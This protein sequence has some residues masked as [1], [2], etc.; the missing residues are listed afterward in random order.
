MY[1]P[2][3]P[4]SY[5]ESEQ[6]Y[7]KQDEIDKVTEWKRFNT[8]NKIDSLQKGL[9]P[10][11]LDIKW[12]WTDLYFENEEYRESRYVR[13]HC[14]HVT[15]LMNTIC[16]NERK[17]RFFSG[18]MMEL[19]KKN[20]IKPFLV[21]IDNKFIS[22]D[23]IKVVRSDTW[24][25]LIVNG[26]VKFIKPQKL[27]ILY[28]PCHIRYDDT[29]SGFEDGIDLLSFDNNGLFD[30]DNPTYIINTDEKDMAGFKYRDV[31]DDSFD[32]AIDPKR[33]ITP[34]NIVVFDSDTRELNN[35]CDI[36]TE[37]ENMIR[38][39]K[40]PY[41]AFIDNDIFHFTDYEAYVKDISR[42]V[43]IENLNDR[44]NLDESKAFL[45]FW[46]S[47]LIEP[48]RY[49][50]KGNTL[51]FDPE[52]PIPADTTVKIIVMDLDDSI[53]FKD[54][55]IE[56]ITTSIDITEKNQSIF[57]IPEDIKD[58]TD[59][60]IVFKDGVLLSPR[61]YSF[62]K[63]YDDSVKLIVYDDPEDMIKG[64][65]ILLVTAKYR[66]DNIDLYNS[67][68]EY[69]IKMR[70]DNLLSPSYT[71]NEIKI[72]IST[73]NKL[74]PVG[75]NTNNTMLFVNSVYYTKE[76]YSID[77]NRLLLITESPIPANSDVTIV[78]S[79]RTKKN[80][81][82][83][84]I[85]WS[86]R[87]NENEAAIIRAKNTNEVKNVISSRFED[88]DEKLYRR[89]KFRERFDYE[90]SKDKPYSENHKEAFENTF[91]TDPNKYNEVYEKSKDVNIVVYNTYDLKKKIDDSGKI[92]MLRDKYD[93]DMYGVFPMIF[94][95]GLCD[96]KA[97]NH[98][99]YSGDKFTFPY[100]GE[101]M[102]LT[103]VYFHKVHTELL[104]INKNRPNAFNVKNTFIPKDDIVLLCDMST[105]G[106]TY[107][108]PVYV[109]IAMKIDES[110]EMILRNKKHK[111]LGNFAIC[112]RR[113]FIHEQY[114]I[115]S[116]NE[117]RIV[118]SD[119]FLTAYNPDNFMIF[120]NGKFISR[121]DYR[122]LLPQ[123]DNKYVLNRE[124]Y[125]KFDPSTKHNLDVYYVSTNS[126]DRLY[127][128][129]DLVTKAEYAYALAD[130]QSVFTIPYP[131]KSYPRNDKELFSVYFNGEYIDKSSYELNDDQIVFNDTSFKSRDKLV[132]IFPYYSPSWYDDM[133]V[134]YDENIFFHTFQC[135]ADVDGQT[136][137]DFN[138]IPNGFTLESQKNSLTVMINSTYAED[139]SFLL[140]SRYV[141]FKNTIK[142]LTDDIPI[143]KGSTITAV[144]VSDVNTEDT[145][146]SY[147][148][149]LMSDN[150]VE[151][152][153]M[154]ITISERDQ[155]AFKLPES[156]RMYSDALL[157]MKG[158]MLMDPS[159]YFVDAD[160]YLVFTDKP[161][162]VYLDEFYNNSYI[163]E[164]RELTLVLAKNKNDIAGN[165]D[166]DE[167]TKHVHFQ[168]MPVIFEEDTT[169]IR[170]PTFSGVLNYYSKNNVM[171]F[172][173]ST[174]LSPDRYDIKDGMI[175]KLDGIPFRKDSRLTILVAYFVKDRSKFDWDMDEH[176]CIRFTDTYSLPTDEN[177][178]V[179]SIPFPTV[180]TD[181][182]FMIFAGDTIIP[183]NRYD[184]I[185]E[186]TIQIDP[187]VVFSSKD[188]KVRFVFVHN[189]SFTKIA[190]KEN[191]YLITNP[192]VK[193][194]RFDS[195]YANLV[196]MQYKTLLFI[197]NKYID[198][199]E[200]TIDN[201]HHK[202]MI[203]NPNLLKKFKNKYMVMY[204]FY[205][206]TN[207]N[208]A[209]AYLPQSGYMC[210]TRPMQ[211]R[212]YRKD[213]YLI[214]VNGKMIYR[215]YIEDISN[216]IKKITKDIGTIYDLYLV[217]FAPLI[218]EL[219]SK[220]TEKENS[221]N[222]ILKSTHI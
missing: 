97:N 123:V 153:K 105:S 137:F 7:S 30:P 189:R 180:F 154:N 160:G 130:K 86:Y 172:Y 196:Y 147:K 78:Y 203:N 124:I 150:V 190:M 134:T 4:D 191:R 164:G 76:R 126:P 208:A 95:N 205:T 85:F 66:N 32:T 71:S 125:F 74:V 69:H 165:S 68:T 215:R 84:S 171:L 167:N 62:T 82:M 67:G 117:N 39:E 70:E 94:I 20:K 50:L 3:S 79:Y 59:S 17:D 135:T 75:L 56:I 42:S 213:M 21:F 168:S 81:F 139:N 195:P 6:G 24:E 158:S 63:Y 45:V 186:H 176:D 12:H 162:G 142:F 1:T 183:S 151:L 161:E 58:Y 120:D 143:H 55:D 184:R 175:T 202:L 93:G 128:N 108:Q 110:G 182:E 35:T 145:F 170:I 112:S 138:G 22:W 179:Y 54:S 111:N 192:N 5:Q 188:H 169:S 28:L 109:P 155:Q 9:I 29:G 102:D 200:Y 91:Y 31:T 101:A 216:K 156:I 103:I 218:S 41:E 217:N 107:A 152:Y 201:Q 177:G 19:Y 40:G 8:Y 122:V 149:E 178:L 25:Y 47:V 34:S 77:K 106:R 127:V 46:N 222:E 10:Q 174:Y 207:P 116:D 27:D 140:K 118:L 187:R 144:I 204:T 115:S 181:T 37:N 198:Q 173:Q 194:Y 159:R 104:T 133:M 52:Y 90:S 13:E 206:G 185:D 146:K 163:T 33:T 166:T 83:A 89:D 51:T 23:R 80:K 57:E 131:F 43:T 16:R 148:P 136:V 44:G 72:P 211:D 99:R 14:L 48:A 88:D 121:Y 114:T 129:G 53:P 214:F 18:S 119:K 87:S 73:Y 38:I 2:I 60:T 210:I 197:D 113:Q 49:T 15:G 96:P 220:F 65:N 61:R 193:K 64:Y 92:T 209:I 157:V 221:W 100:N 11:W 132:F 199:T 26:F 212:C 36:Y 98:I 141:V 219:E